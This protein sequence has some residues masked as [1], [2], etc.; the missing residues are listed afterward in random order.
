NPDTLTLTVY[1]L[2]LN[3]LTPQAQDLEPEINYRY[4]PRLIAGILCRAYE[5][6]DT[7][8]FNPTGGQKY[9]DIWHRFIEEVKKDNLVTDYVDTSY[10]VDF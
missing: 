3:E 1:R 2:P 4:H 6:T 10:R 7:E 8:T 9:S 5:K